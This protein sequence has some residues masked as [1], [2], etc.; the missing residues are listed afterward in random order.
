MQIWK[1]T[2]QFEKG[3][4][5]HDIYLRKN[6]KYKG[7]EIPKDVPYSKYYDYIFRNFR[8]D[9]PEKEWTDLDYKAD[10]SRWMRINVARKIKKWAKQKEP[11]SDKQKR[12]IER[13]R[14]GTD[15]DV[16]SSK[17]FLKRLQ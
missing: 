4:F 9:K 6:M 2:K 12:I 11:L 16:H 17:E 5:E 14:N 7:E 3:S 15:Y 10:K 13:V 1:K 8:I